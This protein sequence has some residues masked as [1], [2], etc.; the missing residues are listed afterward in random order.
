[1]KY[2]N[3]FFLSILLL[4]SMVPATLVKAMNADITSFHNAAQ[5]EESNTSNKAQEESINAIYYTP[6]SRA[7]SNSPADS[8]NI[9][10]S[11]RNRARNWFSNQ[12]T[13]TSGLLSRDNNASSD[14]SNAATESPADTNDANTSN[15][16][17]SNINALSARTKLAVGVGIATIIGGGYLTYKKLTNSKPL[18]KRDLIKQYIQLDTQLRNILALNDYQEVSNLLCVYDK[19][20]DQ[21]TEAQR[22]RHEVLFQENELY[23]QCISIL[24]QIKNLK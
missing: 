4:A 9:Q 5:E 19:D 6:D 3:N 7:E 13:W 10:P 11:F 2:T 20:I 21:L 14:D 1:M 16:N 17:A 22:I 15:I 24:D 23:A 12:W 8:D 18:T